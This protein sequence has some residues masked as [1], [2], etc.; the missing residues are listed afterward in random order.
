MPP[1]T[2]LI[3][4]PHRRRGQQQQ[5]RGRIKQQRHHRMKKSQHVPIAGTDQRARYFTGPR[6]ASTVRRS[7]SIAAFSIFR[8][9]RAFASTASLSARPLRLA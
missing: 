3:S 5:N 4:F 2:D 6:S 7:P 1:L 8:S 9:V